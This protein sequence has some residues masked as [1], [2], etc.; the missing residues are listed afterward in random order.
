[1]EE[2]ETVG[3]TVQHDEVMSGEPPWFPSLWH[4]PLQPKPADQLLEI[5]R[6]EGK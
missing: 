5:D 6:A 3:E 2:A 4:D 1:M